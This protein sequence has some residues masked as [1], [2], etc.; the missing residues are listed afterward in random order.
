MKL[1]KFKEGDSVVFIKQ[2]HRHSDDAVRIGEYFKVREVYDFQGITY[3][4]GPRAESYLEQELE[5]K[6]I[7]RSPLY[8]ALK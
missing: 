6:E 3:I 5:F 2:I 4:V 8:E 7:A 1:S